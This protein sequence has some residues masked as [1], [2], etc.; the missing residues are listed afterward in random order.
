MQ[1]DPSCG[2]D[3]FHA[4]PASRQ[5]SGYLYDESVREAT[6]KSYDKAWHKWKAWDLQGRPSHDSW[7]AQWEVMWTV[8]NEQ[9]RPGDAE[10][11]W[12]A[13]SAHS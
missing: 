8:W 4:L 3:L 13:P 11:D 2:G 9:G 12:A 5:K 6:A 10:W 1:R 7:L